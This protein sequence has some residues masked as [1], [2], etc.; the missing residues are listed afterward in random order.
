MLDINLIREDPQA[1]K[2]SLSKRGAD[3]GAAIDAILENDEKWRSL[4]SSSE[5]LKSQRN[6]VSADIAL[7][8][9]N[10]ED[11]SGAI[12]DMQRVSAEIKELDEKGRILREEIDSM[13]LLLPNIPEAGLDFEDR[14]IRQEGEVPA[15]R[16]A[17]SHWEIGEKLGI[18]D[19]KRAAK[20]S[21]S[22]FAV[23][24]GR[25][26]ALE[27]ALIAF[28]LDLHINEGGYTEIMPPVL[29]K[30]EVMKGTGQLPKFKEDMYV[31]GGESPEDERYLIPTAEVPLT[32]F[33]REEILD[34]SELPKKYVAYTPCFRKEAGS[35]GKDTSGVI[36]QHQFNKVEIVNISKPE[37]SEK[38]HEELLKESEEVLKRLGLVYRVIELGSGDFGF[39]AVK[40]WDL[41]VWMPG[42]EK[43]REVSSCSN[44]R[45]FQARRMKT[46]MKTA[47]GENVL[48]HTLNSSGVAVGRIFAAIL[49]NFQTEDS[50][51][52][53]IPEALRKYLGD[54]EY[55]I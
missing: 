14:V 6:K 22:R 5:Q 19:L 55:L 44:C 47:S 39:S 28:M 29:V 11:A 33:H 42:E 10:G 26:A 8:K 31:T 15:A 52:I 49:E 2:D 24:L 43:W 30:E 17:L 27:R 32:N 51:N 20:L 34:E 4:V 48:V 13:M 40:T 41:E 53:K 3:Y 18:L 12:S 50:S 1:V 37:D 23:M 21:G 7:L 36:R 45:D 25:G 46:R 54:S 35:Y 9:K 38:M 16:G